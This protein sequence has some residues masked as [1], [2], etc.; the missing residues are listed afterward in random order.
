MSWPLER[1]ISGGDLL[2]VIT[3]PVEV[4]VRL[5]LLLHFAEF[6]RVLPSGC[7]EWTGHLDD[8]YGKITHD[9]VTYRAYRLAYEL[10]NGPLPAGKVP[11]H[12]CRN[13]ACVNPDHLEAVTQREN[14][15]RGEGHAARNA[16]KTHCDYGHPLSGDNVRVAT[17]RNGTR[18]R[19]CLTCKRRRTKQE[20][21]R[22]RV[23]RLAA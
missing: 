5:A 21:E 11:D 23:K 3:L 20:T 9:G 14:I 8:G 6:V 16:R 10:V 18:Q 22:R 1:V 4:R 19:I 17:K 7:W 12:L 13:R 15:H 2:A